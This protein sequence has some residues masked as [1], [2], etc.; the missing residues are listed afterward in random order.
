M[1]RLLAQTGLTA[2]SALAIAFY[3]PEIARFILLLVC[4]AAFAVLMLIR[5]TRK[6]IFPPVMALVAAIAI[7]VNLGYSLLYVIPVQE[8]LSG[9]NC[10]VEATLIEEPYTYGSRM[11]YRLRA[12]SVNGKRTNVKIMLSSIE[13]IDIE[14][15]DSIAFNADI[16]PADSD[17]NLSKGYYLS[18]YSYDT[19]FEV[20]RSESRPPMY[21]AIKL[22]Q[23]LR[24]AIQHYLP[25]DVA[26]L[27]QA[28]FL[29]DRYALDSDTK[30]DF[31]YAGASHFVVVSGM[32]FSVFCMLFM[33]LFRLLRRRCGMNQNIGNSLMLVIILLYISVT[34]FQPSVVRSGVMMLVYIFG[35]FFR[36]INDSHNSLGLAAFVSL[37]VFSP[38]GAGDIG[39]ILSFAATFA[40]ITWQEPIKE[41]LTIRSKKPDSPLVRAVNAVTAVLSVSLAANIL[42]LPISVLVFRGFSLV[43]LV[44]A[45]LLI[46]PIE[47]LMILSLFLCL[48]FYLGPLTYISLVISWPIYICGRA[49]LFTVHALASLPF[50]YVRVGSVFADIWVGVTVILGVIVIAR[51]NNYRFLPYAAII[52]AVVMLSGAVA[53]TAIELN[54]VALQV[55]DC[56]GM[57]VGL[58]LRGRLILLSMDSNRRDASDTLSDLAARYGSAEVAVCS[59]KRD[60]NNY[61]RL[62][63]REFAISHILMY[64]SDIS[65]NGGAKLWQEDD[66]SAYLGDDAYL[67]VRSQGK[68]LL[69]YADVGE[70]TILVIPDGYP[71]RYIPEEY[72]SA[73]IIVIRRALKGYEGLSCSVLII[74]DSGEQAEESAE[75]MSGSCLAVEYSY[76]GDITVD[77]R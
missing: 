3:L 54:T 66:W 27:C 36:R 44:S 53:A 50:S 65:Y 75:L 52:S 16:S 32:H 41:K 73:D 74:C 4:L 62:S 11:F 29:G 42:V 70:K 72:R 15:Y 30:L 9:E 55:Y 63:E 47:L 18:V 28:V 37:V 49:I 71:Y 68:R 43:T 24:E 25:D 8:E 23:A 35:R 61:S 12:D 20:S 31:R 56:S 60:L 19:Q 46:F 39:L 13:P 57:A 22:R 51:R 69:S 67:S 58:D 45:L 34:G 5:D 7:A 76:N 2:F 17:Y 33:C 10:R 48:F 77:L 21:Y 26:D 59:G 40:I 1:K 38:Y 64:D 14:E 6:K